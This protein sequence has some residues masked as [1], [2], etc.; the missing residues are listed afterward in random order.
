V[1]SLRGGLLAAVIVLVAGAPAAAAEQ[2]LQ[3]DAVDATA[4]PTVSVSV[5]PPG[6]DESTL[7]EGAF[8]VIEDGEAVEATVDRVSG[9]EL[10]V[11]LVMDTSGSMQG[12]PMEAAK[13]AAGAFVNRMPA[14]ARIA[15]VGFGPFATVASALGTDRAATHVAINGLVPTGETALFDA[16]SLAT[17]QFSAAA[18]RRS[19]VVLSDG[20]DTT[21][22]ASP[23]QVLQ[24][25]AD[26]RARVDAAVLRSPES[27]AGVLAT[28][29]AAGGGQAV[30]VAGPEALDAVYDD[31]ATRLV[32]T[33]RLTWESRGSGQTEVEVAV[34]VGG[35]TAVG[36]TTVDLP[37]APAP[38]P[39]TAAPPAPEAPAGPP[40]WALLAG[41]AAVFLA[42]VLL[43][44][45][46]LERNGIGRR[47]DRLT[48]LGSA[49]GSSSLPG[50][51][52]LAERAT[53]AADE[54]LERRGRKASLHAALERAGL[55]LRPGELLV[56]AGTIAAVLFLAGAALSGVLVGLLLAAITLASAKALVSVLTARRT[57]AFSEQL[58]DTLQILAGSLRAGYGLVQAVDAVSQEAP[59]PTQEEFR[60]VVLEHRLGRDLTDSLQAMSDRIDT[61][62]LR[63]VVQAVDIHR[64]IGGDLASILDTVA[65]TIRERAQI[66]R[67]VRALTA[68]GR[69]S[70]YILIALPLVLAGIMRVVNPD[71]I[72]G[73]TRGT[74]LGM[75]LVGLGLL[76]VGALWFRKLCRFAV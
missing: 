56:L 66:L 18:G 67:Q 58:P 52:E 16:V 55:D 50:L 36:R 33:Y 22:A 29:A 4:A 53:A 12:A 13:A 23:E 20:A 62:D 1:R 34:E 6:A 14:S 69:L 73:L 15:V 5:T 39:E 21:S 24:R 63:W 59:S 30:E 9:E 10:E 38:A 25:V 49:A 51:G 7:P 70:A 41:T 64:E 26:A 44:L 47:R 27:D 75:A 60:R 3:I 68:E 46:V 2:P 35:D 45:S 32:S 74:G 76:G 43:V 48:R 72:L 61:E 19:I 28:L 71:Y 40:T 8:T 17:Q 54:A 31:V 37:E 42:L 11:V 65:G 57:R